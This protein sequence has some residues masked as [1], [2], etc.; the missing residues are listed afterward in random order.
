MKDIVLIGGGG[1]RKAVIDVLE[2]EPK[3]RKAKLIELL[4]N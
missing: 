4:N 1:H 2:L 3:E